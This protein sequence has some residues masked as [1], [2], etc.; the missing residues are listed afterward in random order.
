MSFAQWLVESGFVFM[1][2]MNNETY[3]VEGMLYMKRQPYDIF[4][5][6]DVGYTYFRACYRKVSSLL[7]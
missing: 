2:A 4:M 1:R 3:I 6:V 5:Y 7:T